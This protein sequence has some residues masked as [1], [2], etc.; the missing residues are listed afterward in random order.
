MPLAS[1]TVR[2]GT[3]H[4]GYGVGVQDCVGMALARLA[5]ASVLSALARAGLL[6]ITGPV[7]RRLNDTLRDLGGLP[8]RRAWA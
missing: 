4:V 3:E 2:P 6:E 1:S 5:G 7:E 8:V